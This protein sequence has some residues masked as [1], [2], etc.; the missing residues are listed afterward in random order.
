VGRTPRRCGA[1]SLVTTSISWPRH[2]DPSAASASPGPSGSSTGPGRCGAGTSRISPAVGRRRTASPSSTRCPRKWI[3]TLLSAEETA[4]QTQVVFFDAL[5]AEGSSIASRS[6][7]TLVSC[8]PATGSHPLGRLGQRPAYDCGRHPQLHGA[9]LD[10]PALRASRRA[11]RPSTRRQLLRAR[12]GQLA[13]SRGHRR[14]RG[15]SAPNS[16]AS[17]P[18]TTRCARTRHRLRHSQ[19]R[20]GRTRRRHP[21]KPDATASFGPTKLGEPP[22][23]PP[24]IAQEHPR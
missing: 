3:S 12:Q 1:Y 21:P 9:V 19:R 23:D 2:R 22:D 5:D 6:G 4:V 15:A 24:S 7:W 20:T 10:R 11:H 16:N 13:A 14:P 17:G 8:P 18:S